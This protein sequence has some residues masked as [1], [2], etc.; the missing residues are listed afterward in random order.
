[1]FLSSLT[2]GMAS[3]AM[4]HKGGASLV[5]WLI[6][7]AALGAGFLGFELADFHS[8]AQQGGVPSRSG[9][10]SAYYALVGLHGTH[11]SFGLLWI[12]VML[13]QLTVLGQTD[14]VKTRLLMLGLY[15]HF[16]DLI[17]VGIFSIVFLAGVA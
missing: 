4:K 1:L 17:W 11:I 14:R 7:T 10:L 8:M 9:W 6:V 5:I 15:W 3:L 2:Y 13:V 12:T 16:L